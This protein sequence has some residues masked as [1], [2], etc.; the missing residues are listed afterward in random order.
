M[1]EHRGVVVKST[2]DGFLAHFDGPGRAVACARAIND[3]LLDVG[4]QVR[5]GVHTGEIELRGD[6]VGGLAVHLAARVAGR[7]DAGEV[8]AT[9]TVKDLTVGSGLV[10]D[11]RGEQELKGVP[12]RWALYA[13]S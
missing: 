7:A 11:D 4:L 10:F 5:A 13:V 1:A 2:G 12:D 8:L 9:R 6:D 3:R